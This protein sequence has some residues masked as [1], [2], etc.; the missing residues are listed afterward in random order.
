M[1]SGANL[2]CACSRSPMGFSPHC[3]VGDGCVDIIL[4]R[5]TSL[6]NNIRI[7]LRLSSKKKNVV[8]VDI[9]WNV[10]RFR[11]TKTYIRVS[12]MNV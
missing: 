2:A 11:S 6:F 7:L 10:S 9:F 12:A 1:V 5:H 3:H 8:R 4:V